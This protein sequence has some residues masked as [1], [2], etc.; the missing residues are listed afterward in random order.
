MSL[1]QKGNVSESNQQMSCQRAWC[2]SA[3]LDAG[4]V[5]ASHHNAGKQGQVAEALDSTQQASWAGGQAAAGLDLCSTQGDKAPGGWR[6]LP[7]SPC[8]P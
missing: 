3:A 1:L 5:Q 8:I 2:L 6:R 4:S 7:Q